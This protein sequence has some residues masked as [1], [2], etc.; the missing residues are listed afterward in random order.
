MINSFDLLDEHETLRQEV[1]NSWTPKERTDRLLRS[2]CQ[3]NHVGD[4]RATTILTIP[5]IDN[6]YFKNRESLL[7]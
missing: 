1:E 5:L 6:P 2:K 7:E 4:V 3:N